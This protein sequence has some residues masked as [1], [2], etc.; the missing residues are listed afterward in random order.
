MTVTLNIPDAIAPA[1]VENVCAATNWRA[2]NGQTKAQWAKA[3]LIAW[4]VATNNQGASLRA[5]ES[6]NADGATIT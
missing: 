6:A 5:L 3:Q 4:L 2:D 1:L